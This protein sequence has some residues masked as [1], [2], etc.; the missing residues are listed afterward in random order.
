MADRRVYRTIQFFEMAG[1]FDD[2]DGPVDVDHRQLLREV[3][4]LPFKDAEMSRYWP[5]GNGDVLC[6][7]SVPGHGDDA[8]QFSR[9]RRRDLPRVENFGEFSDLNLPNGAGLADSIHVVFF[10]DGIVGAEFYRPGPRMSQLAEYL[11]RK[12]MH[13]VPPIDFYPLVRGTVTDLLH[14]LTDIRTIRVGFRG[15]TPNLIERSSDSLAAAFATTDD[16]VRGTPEVVLELRFSRIE[17]TDAVGE[18][19]PMLIAQS[20]TGIYHS[21]VTSLEVKGKNGS[22]NRVETV[23]LFQDRIT[24]KRRINRLGDEVSAVDSDDA[25]SV[26]RQTYDEVRDEILNSKV[27]P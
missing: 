24:A 20:R 7:F 4:R 21:N 19:L 5:L 9:I 8:M 26:I 11:Q 12:T 1:G 14:Q 27:M 13:A 2:E 18:N 22:T 25:I 23:D 3:F 6:A 17:R 16:W 15:S 10:D